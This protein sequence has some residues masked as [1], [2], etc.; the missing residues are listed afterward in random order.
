MVEGL[1]SVELHKSGR[2]VVEKPFGRDG[3]SATELDKIIHRS[4]PEEQV[5]RIDHFLGKDAVQN[6]MVFRF[7]NTIL[8][9]IWNRQYIREIQ[10]TLAEDF[11][12]EGR[13]SFYDDVG[14][15]R[16]VIQ[17]HVFQ[18]VTLLAMEPP[19]SDGPD[20]LRDERSRVLRAINAL[21][22]G[23]VSEANTMDTSRKMA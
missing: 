23:D 21:T 12:V 3:A 19:L 7:S 6:L 17:N 1:S 13:G 18:M 11:G 2:L 15:I 9:P 14:A 16:D 10:I 8:E 5:F 20:A 4:F 22:P